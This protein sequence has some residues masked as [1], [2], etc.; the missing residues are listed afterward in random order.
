MWMGLV[1][2]PRI[3]SYWQTS[4]L[5]KNDI[6]ACM[7]TRNRFQLLLSMWHLADNE[8]ANPD[9]RLHKIEGFIEMMIS[10]FCKVRLPGEVITV[11]ETMIPFRGRLL[12]RQY[13][14]NKA[15]KFGVKLFKLCESKRYTYTVKLYSGKGDYQVSLAVDTVLQLCAP[16]VNAGRTVCTDNFYTCLPLATKLLD[17]KTHLVGTIRVNRKGLPGAVTKSKLK[18]GEVIARENKDGIVVMKWRDKRD[19]S[20]LSTRHTEALVQ[21]G[22]PN[23]QHVDIVKPEAVVFYNQHKQGIDLSDQMSSYHTALRR[24]VKWYHKVAIELLLGT[25][26]VNAFI[27]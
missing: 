8:M 27:R 24:S 14:P 20:I 1:N 15:H 13:I 22:K 18:K 16:Y 3:A 7:M 11:D 2:M 21:T 10:K 17:V 25:A 26:V 9:N 23:R 5:Y 4:T 12:F 6:A 19:V